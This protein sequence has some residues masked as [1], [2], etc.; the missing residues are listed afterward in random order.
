MKDIIKKY[1]FKNSANLGFEVL[2]LSERVRAKREMM[3]NPHRAQFYHVIWIENGH[4]T[5]FVDFKPIPVK[6]NTLLFVPS[7]S[8]NMYDANGEYHGKAILFT[9]R[10]FCKSKQDIQFLRT[11]Q[12]YSDLYETAKIQIDPETSDLKFFLN[13]MKTEFLREPDNFQFNILHNMLHVFLSKAERE[14]NNQGFIK[15][16]PSIELDCLIEFKDL[17]EE[18]FRKNKLVSNYASELN[19]S[20]KQLHKAT[21][22]LLDKT[23]KQIIDERII[24][25]AKRLLA[26]S[27]QSVKEISYDL[28]YNEPTNFVK[29][30]KKHTNLTPVEF[31]EQF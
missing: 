25:E 12:L 22:T 9:D 5:H 4:G 30:F 20:E 11:T 17:L 15:L 1:S 29:Y 31:R 8:V 7:N 2:E 26:H 23:P 18:N 3:A 28:G 14:M 19:I 10:F 6:N 13:A 16:K 27:N 24:L 21:T